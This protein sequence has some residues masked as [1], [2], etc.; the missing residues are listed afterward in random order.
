MTDLA[1]SDVSFPLADWILS[2]SGVP[3]N[4]SLSGM[5]GELTT[6]RRLLNDPRP[7]P[8]DPE[9]LRRALAQVHRVS[10]D[11]IVLTH[12]ATESN[13]LVATSWMRR[14]RAASGALLVRRP[15]YPPLGDGARA[16]GFHPQR[17]PR[18]ARGGVLSNPWNPEGRL[19]SSEDV[20]AWGGSLRNVLIDEIFREFT[21][22]PGAASWHGGRVRFWVSSSFTKIYGADEIRLGYVIAPEEEAKNLE[23]LSALLLD[24]PA[25]ASVTAGLR[26]LRNR[27]RILQESRELFRRNLRILRDLVPGVPELAAPVWFDR[28]RG[29]LPSRRLSQA[30][31]KGGVL[32]GP[33]ELFGDGRGVRIC[34]TRRSFERDLRAYLKVRR[35][36]L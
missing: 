1:R 34:L 14:R 25:R 31:L 29:R 32:V 36:F 16:L 35:R 19:W 6:V 2:H 13:A 26:L 23:D 22:G 17:H 4:L 24:P 7:G 12:G 20:L 11:R 21:P 30:A 5:T 9:D 18:G 3:H 15:E 10:R 33:G 27:D 8:S 28:G